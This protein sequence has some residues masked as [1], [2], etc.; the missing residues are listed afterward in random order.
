VRSATVSVIIPT[1]NRAAYIGES[2]ASVL[3][4]THSP[5]EILII[6]DGSTD[7]T[8]S[9]VSRFDDP[10]I[11]YVV[12]PHA[13]ISATR[14]TGIALASGDYLAFL[15]SDDRWRTTM[16]AKQLS[17]LEEDRELV[18][19]FTNFIRFKG[20]PPEFFG[21]QFKYCTEFAHLEGEVP[22]R[23]GGFILDGD[24]FSTFVQFHEFPAYLQC[25]VFRRSIISDMRMNESLRI[26]ED[27]EFVLRAFLRGKVA[28]LPEVL[29]DIRRH[30][31]NITKEVGE[32]VELDKVRAL[33]SLRKVV[34]SGRRRTALNDRLVK[35]HI[36]SATA[37]IRTGN[38]SQGIKSYLNALS[39]PGSTRR[40]LKGFARTIFSILTSLISVDNR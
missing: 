32:L 23:N 8:P 31:S 27:T 14:N 40:K 19:S 17:M 20:H 11:Q 39:T 18:C 2:I 22:R 28:F 21:E 3:A 38:R 6:D 36:D 12:M 34:D 7:Q 16:L 35:A 15:D 33:L 30:D 5:T 25:I 13:G 29:A 24:P 9:I 37:L 10:R 1:Y 4:Q 26:G